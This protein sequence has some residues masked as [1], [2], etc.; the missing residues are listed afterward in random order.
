VEEEEWENQRMSIQAV[1]PW[2][3]SMA[4]VEE[5]EERMNLLQVVNPIPIC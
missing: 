3:F 4:M 5:E 1:V 2:L